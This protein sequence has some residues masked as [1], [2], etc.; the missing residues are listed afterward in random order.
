MK[1]AKLLMP[2]CMQLSLWSGFIQSIAKP[3]GLYTVE[4]SK[5]LQLVLVHVYRGVPRGVLRVLEH[6]H[7]PKRLFYWNN[8]LT[9][10]NY[11]LEG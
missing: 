10:Q 7:R 4:S 2:R 1:A 5:G 9:S 11:L 8:N 6:P 3:Q